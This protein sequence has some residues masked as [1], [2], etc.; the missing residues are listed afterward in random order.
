VSV[1]NNL[2]R[3]QQFIADLNQGDLESV[4]RNIAP[5]FFNYAPPTGEPTATD[6]FYEMLSDLG[7]A[8][9]NW[10]MAVDDLRMED[11][12]IRGRLE[13]E[14]KHEGG[15]WGAPATGNHVTW[16]VDLKARPVDSRFAVSADNFPPLAILGVLRQ[17][18]L[19]PPPDKMDTPPKHPSMIPDVLLQMAFTGQMAPK[20]CSHL[21][22][23]KFVEV[24]SNVCEQCVASGDIWPALRQCLVCGFVGCCYTS[25]N[26]HAKQHYEQT[27]HA[28]FRSVRLQER[29]VWCYADDAFFPGR[30]LD[31]KR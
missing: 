22:Q 11:D 18:E 4:R 10:S 7:A 13:W 17:M 16:E 31:K 21:D 24:T 9:P 19:V 26:K 29:W 23:I 25:K 3:F 6:V 8:L 2:V 20:P 12:L 28:I 15:L 5:A 30:I 27:G 1:E 14:G